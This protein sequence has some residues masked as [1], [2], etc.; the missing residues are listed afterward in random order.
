MKTVNSKG[1][2]R[3][4]RLGPGPDPREKKGKN[5]R[6]L[7]RGA[8]KGHERSRQRSG[9]GGRPPGNGQQ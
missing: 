9:R 7:L 1:G 8:G 5:P 4:G 3:Q 2:K 6:R